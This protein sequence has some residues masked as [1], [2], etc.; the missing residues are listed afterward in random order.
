MPGQRQGQQ[1][2]LPL[3]VQ[4]RTD[5]GGAVD[6]GEPAMKQRRVGGGSC[7]G[8]AH[9]SHSQ[10]QGPE[11]KASPQQHAMSGGGGGTAT[12]LPLAWTAAQCAFAACFH[13]PAFLLSGEPVALV[14]GH[15]GDGVAHILPVNALVGAADAQ[16]QP[17][18]P[19][20][21]DGASSKLQTMEAAT[22][23]AAATSAAGQDEVLKQLRAAV[24]HPA[25]ASVASTSMPLSGASRSAKCTPES[26]SNPSSK[27][28]GGDVVAGTFSKV[29]QLQHRVASETATAALLHAWAVGDAGGRNGGVA[30]GPP[31]AVAPPPAGMNLAVLAAAAASRRPRKQARP[32]SCQ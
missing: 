23:A 5:K 18:S 3:I 25:T 27:V 6:Y 13:F 10:A 4:R 8:L 7:H 28:G 20:G 30:C 1:T 14:H 31:A 16:K 29:Q 22:A 11:L 19:T 12:A 2:R 26:T 17:V 9:Y 32:V 24:H 15:A 21:L